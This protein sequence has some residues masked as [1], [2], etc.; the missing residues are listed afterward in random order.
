[1]SLSIGI[2]GCGPSGLLAAHAAN[3]L[4]FTPTILSIKQPSRQYGAQ[5]LHAPIHGV[6]NR[7]PD[8]EV[9]YHLRGSSLVYG[10]KVYG[11]QKVSS[12]FGQFVGDGEVQEAWDLRNA[13]KKLWRMYEG[14]IS[15]YVFDPG[16]MKILIGSQMFDYC[17]STIPAS[18]IC[19]MRESIH[20]F[21]YQPAWVTP[22]S[23]APVPGQPRL[24]DGDEDFVVYNGEDTEPWYRT[25]S[26]FGHTTTEYPYVDFEEAPD[27]P[28]AFLIKK[29]LETDCNCWRDSVL[30]A[31]RYG[32]W[33]KGVLTHHVYEESLEYLQNKT[34]RSLY[35]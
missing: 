6:T 4:G 13:Y 23:P 12:S 26:V 3:Q 22:R 16:S 14:Q 19:Y 1:M 34:G 10:R 7:S 32:Q 29:P 35:G 30:K 24:P 18:E 8:G 17:I 20:S 25:S 9:K 11:A 28:G 15:N 2:L 5:W 21:K 33:K 31:G 27:V